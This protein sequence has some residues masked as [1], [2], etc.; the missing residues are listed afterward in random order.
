MVKP[1]LAEYL[2]GLTRRKWKWGETDCL[3]I[4][5]DW[6]R[7]NH[8]VDPAAAYRGR[9]HSEDEYR[10]LLKEGGGIVPT[11]NRALAQIDISRTDDPKPGDIGIIRAPTMV[12]RGRVHLGRLGAIYVE[13]KQWAHIM[14]GSLAIASE[15][16]VR[17]VAAWAV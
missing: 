4:L 2:D 12:R 13:R 16:F 3:M 9:Y 11:V 10:A 8:G 6:V 14:N 1:T 7:L 15:K 17:P 5:A